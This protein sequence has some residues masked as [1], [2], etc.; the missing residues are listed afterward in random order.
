MMQA[1]QTSMAEYERSMERDYPVNLFAIVGWNFLWG[2]GLP[3]AMFSTSVP[4]YLGVLRAPKV[5]IGFILSFPML[6]S[7]AQIVAGYLVPAEKRL[8]IFRWL[9]LCCPLPWF[10]YSFAGFFGG[11]AWPPWFHFVAFTFSQACFMGLM[12]LTGSL[13]W[14]IMTD[15][16]PLRKRGLLFGLRMVAMGFPALAM[17]FVAN[18]VIA[19]W[20]S[21][22]NFHAAFVIGAAIYSLSSL[23]LWRLRDHVN[24][25]HASERTLRAS[26]FLRYLSGTLHRLWSNPNY[27]VF[28]FFMVLLCIAANAAPFMVDAARIQLHASSQAQG[29]FSIAYLAS[30][31]C[32][33][34][35]TG[36]LADKFGYRLIGSV[37]SFIMALAFLI[38]LVSARMFLWY[39]AYG[40]YA[41]SINITAMLLCN[42]GVELCPKEQPSGI[43]A[44]GNILLVCFV[45]FG[46][47]ISGW[48]VDKVGSYQPVFVANFVLSIVA[49]FGFALIVREPRRG[50]LYTIVLAPR[51]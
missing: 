10:L 27:R 1:A 14:E 47:T 18:R 9:M 28:I 26:S 45:M 13:Y 33:G 5:L 8:V 38:C 40:I 42:M 11:E 17:G 39:L 6:F 36:M 46:T 44:G 3:F 25:T 12:C 21:P 20:P 22:R 30:I 35:G 23:I 49:M 15:N 41:I 48:V 37:T 32:V 19:F 24:P 16:T 51:N 4:A 50:K 43:L 34:W 31:L 29:G 7:S 2:F